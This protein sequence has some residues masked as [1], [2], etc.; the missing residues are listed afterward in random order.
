[1][2]EELQNIV[3]GFLTPL[4]LAICYMNLQMIRPIPILL[5]TNNSRL[6]TELVHVHNINCCLYSCI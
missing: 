4:K 1:M 2:L 6:F 3:S 5:H